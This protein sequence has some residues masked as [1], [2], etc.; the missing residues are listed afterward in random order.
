MTR[1][2][3]LERTLEAPVSQPPGIRTAPSTPLKQSGLQWLPLSGN[4]SQ[5]K[6]VD[7]MRLPQS[8]E[9][10]R[11]IPISSIYTPT[12]SATLPRSLMRDFSSES[13]IE[14]GRGDVSV[15]VTDY[16]SKSMQ[17]LTNSAQG[18]R[19]K[20]SIYDIGSSVKSQQSDVRSQHSELRSQHSEVR[21]QQS[22]ARSQQSVYLTGQNISSTLS[23]TLPRGFGSSK[24]PTAASQALKP[25]VYAPSRFVIFCVSMSSW[26]LIFTN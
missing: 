25:S 6:D 2:S 9:S 4:I 20:L 18:A 26:M 22:E 21:S 3:S 7:E 17:S 13:R 23:Q 11:P 5:S 16:G 12:S 8:S 19:E 24:E 15:D 14:G 10:N 1:L